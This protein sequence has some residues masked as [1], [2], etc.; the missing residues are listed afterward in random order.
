[1]SDCKLQRLEPKPELVLQVYDKM[2]SAPRHYGG[3]FGV[4]ML[5]TLL[6][7]ANHCWLVEDK[8]IIIVLP[9]IPG[10]AECHISFW[11]G[12]LRG[13]EELCR[14][15]AASLPYNRLWAAIP[16]EAK[17]VRFFAKR[18]GFKTTEIDSNKETLC[19][20]LQ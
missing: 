18:I 16:L 13:R 1:M 10:E 19:L 3:T 8:G 15:L 17:T 11:D 14:E 5:A 12:R 4:E 9:T 6:V 2:R 20:Q 7:I